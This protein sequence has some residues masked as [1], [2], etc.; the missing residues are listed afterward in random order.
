MVGLSDSAS[1]IISKVA[2]TVAVAGLLLL[3]LL[4]N[5]LSNP[6]AYPL[7]RWTASLLLPITNG[8]LTVFIQYH[9]DIIQIPSNET[10]QKNQMSA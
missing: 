4:S 2:D 9:S 3:Q 1:R 8:L 5:V 10:I 7:T 6:D